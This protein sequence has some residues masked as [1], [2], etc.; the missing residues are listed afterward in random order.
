MVRLLVK[1]AIRR[2]P[3]FEQF[4]IFQPQA[5]KELRALCRKYRNKDNI[6]GTPLQ[7]DDIDETGDEVTENDT[8]QDDEQ[9]LATSE[10]SH[11]NSM[12][13]NVRVSTICDLRIK[14][15]YS[16]APTL[17]MIRCINCMF[18]LLAS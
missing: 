14:L 8:C 4:F 15:C 12:E 10:L 6:Q 13:A 7:E 1:P 17:S 11:E 3:Q 18:G 5:P 9:S 16:F 2:E